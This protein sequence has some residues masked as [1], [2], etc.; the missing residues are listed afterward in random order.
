M[1]KAVCLIVFIIVSA[2]CL[3]DTVNYAW[4]FRTG[5]PQVLLA[6]DNNSNVYVSSDRIY[7]FNAAD[8]SLLWTFKPF[9][10]SPSKPVVHNGRV[11]FQSGGLYCL[12][13]LTGELQWDF[14]GDDWSVSQPVVMDEFVYIVIQ[15]KLYC[16]SSDTGHRHWTVRTDSGRILLAAAGTDVLV[17]AQGA[18]SCYDGSNG[19]QLWRIEND[20]RLT[21]LVATNQTA[22]VA[23]MEKYLLGIN[24]KTGH[25]VWE[26]KLQWPVFAK[27]LFYG[28]RLYVAAGELH[29]Y[30]A[31]Y[32]TVL[33][34]FATARPAWLVPPVVHAGSVFVKDISGRLYK[35]NADS[36]KEQETTMLPPGRF[37]IIQ[38][39]KA[40]VAAK[41][42]V[43]G[44]RLN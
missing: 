32:G 5:F 10:L 36:G 7:C 23:T 31:E 3:E 38:R 20:V 17:A 16:L 21:V 13:A 27:P 40:I 37:I 29:C 43:R 6:T 39:E 41:Y 42:Y 33:W 12:D 28:N 4:K 25:I 24:V 26:K 8:G 2:G 14:W 30:D 22:F 1:L 34:T 18:L 44:V 35:I 9:G 11:Y 15:S 19:K